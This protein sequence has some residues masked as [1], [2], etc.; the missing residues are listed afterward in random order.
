MLFICTNTG[1]ASSHYLPVYLDYDIGRASSER[2]ARGTNLRG[3]L[4]N[5]P[6]NR[7]RERDTERKRGFVLATT[8]NRGLRTIASVIAALKRAV[9]LNC[10]LLFHFC[11]ARATV[12]DECSS[13]CTL[14]KKKSFTRSRES[15]STGATHFSKPPISRDEVLEIACT[16]WLSTLNEYKRIRSGDSFLPIFYDAVSCSWSS[17]VREPRVTSRITSVTSASIHC[18]WNVRK[19]G[20]LRET[21]GRENCQRKPIESRE[22]S[23][24]NV[25]D[26]S[27]LFARI[28]LISCDKRVQPR[29]RCRCTRTLLPRRNIL[30]LRHPLK[31]SGRHDDP[32][33]RRLT[34]KCLTRFRKYVYLIYVTVIVVW[35][36]SVRQIDKREAK[37]RRQTRCNVISDVLSC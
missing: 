21:R 17:V 15:S 37:Q 7:E 28:A 34:C 33:I 24:S 12:T 2:I 6:E 18:A 9:Y 23:V 3:N 11:E 4:R 25:N 19:A 32:K 36:S 29:D 10:V 22:A 1:I 13:P 31:L 27:L 8:T 35:R 14:E 16:K 26:I 30:L 5:R 20:S